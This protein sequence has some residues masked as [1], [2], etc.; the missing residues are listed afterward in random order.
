[1]QIED[2][3]LGWSTFHEDPADLLHWNLLEL[4]SGL[5]IREELWGIAEKWEIQT[6]WD[7]GQYSIG[8]E[9]L[10]KYST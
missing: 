6:G 7:F 9:Y 5:H 4:I 1:M 3:S 8:A 2:F 10:L